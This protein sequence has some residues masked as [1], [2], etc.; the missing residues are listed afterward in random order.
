MRKKTS[1]F[2]VLGL[3]VVGLSTMVTFNWLDTF[4]F[5]HKQGKV[6]DGD[7]EFDDDDGIDTSV[8]YL[9]GERDIDGN[10]AT[11]HLLK[12]HVRSLK[13]LSCAFATDR[14]NNYGVNIT[15]NLSDI[16]SNINEK[17]NKTV[18]GAITGDFPFWSTNRTGYVIRNGIVYRNKRKTSRF[19]DLVVKKD[20]SIGFMKEGEMDV[21]EEVG[22]PSEKYHH[23]VSFGPVL[24][25]NGEIKVTEDQEIGGNSWVN[26]PRACFGYIDN[27]NFM[28][29]ATEAKDRTSKTLCSF[30]LY[31]LAVFL[32]ENGCVGA[33]NFDGGYSAGLV[34]NN[35][36]VYAP[37]RKVG[38]IL[39][40]TK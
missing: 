14:D 21:N 2:L 28:F 9:T 31:D 26:N 20:S 27:H 24:L 16:V 40:I 1:L 32:K 33:Y 37:N 29:L 6:I 12:I 4:Y 8:T 10:K 19:V 34:Y 36:V 11:Y 15:Q 39:Y 13:D 35:E 7:T 23:V 25:D 3:T 5:A 38:D 22:Q 30:R 17:S 18:L